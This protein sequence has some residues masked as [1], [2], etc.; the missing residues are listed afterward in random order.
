MH[1]FVLLILK[2]SRVMYITRVLN[3]Y[4]AL[5]WDNN[6]YLSVFM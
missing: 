1:I 6:R 2:Q 3:I 5:N 4:W